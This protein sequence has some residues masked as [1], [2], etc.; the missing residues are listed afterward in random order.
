MKEREER[1]CGM[2]RDGDRCGL[3]DDPRVRKLDELPEGWIVMREGTFTQPNGWLW[4]Y[5]GETVTSGRRERA[6]VREREA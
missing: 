2:G 1:K 5:N 4:A 3:L 6:L